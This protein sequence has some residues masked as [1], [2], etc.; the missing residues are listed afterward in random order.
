MKIKKKKFNPL[1]TII[2][3]CFNGE[4]YLKKSINSI[5][6]Q[7]YKNWELIFWDNKSK[8]N[9]KK[10]FKIFSDK[11]L[12]YYKS[13]KFTTLY[14]ARNLA[15]KKAKGEYISFCDTDDW[16]IKSKLKKQVSLIKNN[17]RIKLIYSNLYLYDQQTKKKNYTS[18]KRHLVEK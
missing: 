16:W 14:D 4:K 12:K 17:R 15:I 10:I 9:S 5:L 2:M 3:N 1:I 8:D 11:R 13:K 18:Q 7:S 6:S